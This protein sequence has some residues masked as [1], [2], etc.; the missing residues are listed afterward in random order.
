MKISIVL[1]GVSDQ[2]NRQIDELNQFLNDYFNDYNDVEAW[3][4]CSDE[5]YVHALQFTNQISQLRLIDVPAAAHEEQL[6]NSVVEI[7]Q[8]IMSDCILFPSSLWGSGMAVRLAYRVKGSSMT[9]IRKFQIMD[10]NVIVEKNVYS[11][12]LTAQ[13]KLNQSPYCI[14]VAKGLSGI[15]DLKFGSPTVTKVLNNKIV[16]Q[17]NELPWLKYHDISPREKTDQLNQQEII[18]VAGRGVGSQDGVEKVAA[19]A[20][21][22]QGVLG[23]TRPVVMNAWTDMNKLIGASGEIVSPKL[24]IAVGV[25]GSAAFLIGINQSDF[26]VSINKDSD[27]PIFEASDVV[28]TADYQEIIDELLDLLKTKDVT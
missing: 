4:L 15:K 19:L 9:N 7:Q 18:V 20:D 21:Q 28:I 17:Q 25:S 5:Q 24:C 12:N 26:I 1:N 14:S 3:V 22:L 8:E 16:N 23:A 13:F 27:A 6:V 2:L 10:G 11:N